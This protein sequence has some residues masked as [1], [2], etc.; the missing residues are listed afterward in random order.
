MIDYDEPNG[1]AAIGLTQ[2]RKVGTVQD[3]K[4][5]NRRRKQFHRLIPQSEWDPAIVAKEFGHRLHLARRDLL[6]PG[7]LKDLGGAL[8]T[9]KKDHGL[10]VAQMILAMDQFFAEKGI[11]AGLTE[12]PP[13]VNVFLKYLQTNFQHIKASNIDDAYIASLEGQMDH[14]KAPLRASL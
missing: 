8:R 10:T 5:Q 12:T 3:R 6:T 2:P 14:L 9:W 13:A 1:L 11:I 4:Q 7:K